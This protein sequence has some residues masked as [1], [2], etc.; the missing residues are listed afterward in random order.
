M[1]SHHPLTHQ[2]DTLL[3]DSEGVRQF[4]K[5]LSSSFSSGHLLDFWFACK[6]FR[7]I[8]DGDDQLKLLQ[9]AKAIYRTYIKTDAALS[10][11]VNDSTKREIRSTLSAFS[12]SYHNSMS[13]DKRS[14]V[15]R[16]LFDAAQADVQNLLARSY[17][18]EFLQSDSFRLV[19]QSLSVLECGTS[20]PGKSSHHGCADQSDGTKRGNLPN[21]NPQQCMTQSGSEEGGS[22]PAVADTADQNPSACVME[23]CDTGGGGPTVHIKASAGGTASSDKSR[24][25][26]AES[27]GAREMVT[28]SE[29]ITYMNQTGGGNATTNGGA[30]PSLSGAPPPSKPPPPT[31][32]APAIETTTRKPGTN[33]AEIDPSAFA[34]TLSHRLEKVKE[35]RGKIERLLSRMQPIDP[36]EAGGEDAELASIHAEV[37]KLPSPPLPARSTRLSSNSRRATSAASGD[38]LRKKLSALLPSSGSGVAVPSVDD[39]QVILED[40]CSRIWT[41]ERRSQPLNVC[42][43]GGRRSDVYSISSFDSGVGTCGGGGGGLNSSDSESCVS[44]GGAFHHHHHHQQQHYRWNYAPPPPPPMC[45]FCRRTPSMNST[46]GAHRKEVASNSSSN[47]N[48]RWGVQYQRMQ[49]YLHGHSHHYNLEESDCCGGGRAMRSRSLT[50]DSPS[51]FDSGLSSTYD[52][53]PPPRRSRHDEHKLV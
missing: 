26:T 35:S 40:H 51:V 38:L 13:G 19:H 42:R 44:R 1:D 3:N 22:L 2:L 23:Q 16:S 8:V 7:S 15:L 43:K 27:G 24:R 18:L 36:E 47:S 14:P 28:A 48:Y 20:L 9:V 31:M 52:H 17:F 41:D 46:P 50:S 5:F 49:Q 12:Q 4:H 10:V 25:T 37:N 33:L 34:Q 30:D 29:F 21:I 11:P 6:G 45:S 53:L 32:A 39:A